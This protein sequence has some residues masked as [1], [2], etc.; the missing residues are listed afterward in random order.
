MIIILENADF[1]QN[2]IG[3]IETPYIS[4]KATEMVS[5]LTSGVYSQPRFWAF[6][7][8][9]DALDAAGILDIVNWMSVPSIATSIQDSY[10]NLID[11]T[12]ATNAATATMV[13]KNKYGV[14][15]VY[16]SEVEKKQPYVLLYQDNPSEACI[17]CGTIQ[18]NSLQAHMIITPALRCST[19]FITAGSAATNQSMTDVNCV[20]GVNT[21]IAA[22][23]NNKLYRSSLMC[24]W[25]NTAATI[26]PNSAITEGTNLSLRYLYFTGEVGFGNG[27]VHS[28]GVET[29]HL[30]FTRVL[31][32][33]ECTILTNALN[34]Y[35]NS[36]YEDD[37]T[38]LI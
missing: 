1:S 11:G 31:T 33:A 6:G 27:T 26:N 2:N 15:A 5:H 28:N 12:V 22:T 25:N 21:V 8:F 35:Q 20:V 29:V 30:S 37:I 10:T 38:T 24:K 18:K 13:V 16:D 23:S 34:A 3:Q 9:V 17:A 36:F 14:Y 19:N 4:T 7:K 32:D